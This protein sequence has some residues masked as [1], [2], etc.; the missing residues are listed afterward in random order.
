MQSSENKIDTVDV[1]LIKEI[2][3]SGNDAF[4]DEEY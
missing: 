4:T 2:V 1:N 3:I